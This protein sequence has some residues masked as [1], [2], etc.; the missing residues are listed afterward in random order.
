MTR[1]LQQHRHIHASLKPEGKQCKTLAK[2]QNLAQIPVKELDSRNKKK[3]LEGTS[4][5]SQNDV[6]SNKHLSVNKI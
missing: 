2:A 4:R 3:Y 6:I 1:Y 5:Q